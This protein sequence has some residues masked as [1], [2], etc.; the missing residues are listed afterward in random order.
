MIGVENI[1]VEQLRLL[2]F[3]LLRTTHS[4]SLPSSLEKTL[5]CW[6]TAPLAPHPRQ[7]I[8]KV[9]HCSLPGLPSYLELQNQITWSN[10]YI[11]QIKLGGVSTQSVTAGKVKVGNENKQ[12]HRKIPRVKPYHSAFF[13]IGCPG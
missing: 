12:T 4:E 9:P 7:L 1:Q 5:S 2:F 8:Y 13:L 3:Y 10:P 11:L 6:E